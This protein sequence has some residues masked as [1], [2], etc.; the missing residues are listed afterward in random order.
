MSFWK[1]NWRIVLIGLIGVI[2]ASLLFPT[3]A[4]FIGNYV[5]VAWILLILAITYPVVEFLEKSNEKKEAKEKEVKVEAHQEDTQVIKQKVT[6]IEQHIEQTNQIKLENKNRN[7]LI[8]ELINNNLISVQTLEN[9]IIDKRF[10]SVFCYQVGYK[11]SISEKIR[12]LMITKKVDLKRTYPTIFEK[13]GFV[14]LGGVYPFFIIP[15]DNVYPSSLRSINNMAD[16]ILDKGKICLVDEWNKIKD[17][18]ESHDKEFYQKIK[19]KENPLNFNFLIMKLNRRDIRH[20]FRIKNDFN[21]EFNLELASIVKM[22]DFKTTDSDKVKV[23]NLVQQ[24]SINI[25]IL[26]LGKKDRDK[27][28]ALEPIFKKS[29]VEGG[30]G[31]LNF[32]DYH[33]KNKEDVVKILMKKF[34]KESA[35]SNAE[36][37]LKNSLEYSK[38][39][40][41]LGIEI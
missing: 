40:K 8:A 1:S 37:I 15:E 34:D 36:L 25:L 22:E 6:Q 7:R 38:D 27:I 3:I 39:L 19:D 30:L 12:N 16:Y 24:S 41:E 5:N 21:K 31:I 2:S 11:Y 23:K 10:L 20:R 13:I 35:I 28:L 4:I 33:K 26:S 17:I 32:Y 14:R 9:N 29:S 18:S